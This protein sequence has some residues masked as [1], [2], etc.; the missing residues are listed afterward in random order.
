[1]KL[2]R[3]EHVAIAVNNMA[4]SMKMLEDTLGIDRADESVRER[5]KSASA[6]RNRGISTRFKG[7]F[8]KGRGH[9]PIARV[10]N[11][12]LDF[13]LVEMGVPTTRR[14]VVHNEGRHKFFI[15]N[16]WV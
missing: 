11:V 14:L 9:K 15:Q 10:E 12:L 16:Y 8:A 6:P 7:I 13:G 1:M 2:K 5:A 4:E 3:V